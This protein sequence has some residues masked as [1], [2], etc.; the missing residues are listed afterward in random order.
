VVDVR[1][2]GGGGRAAAR[3]IRLRS[4]ATQVLAFSGYGD[5]NTVLGMLE[6]GAVG[7]LVKGESAGQ[8]LASIKRTT[9]GQ[10]SLSAQV[11]GELIDEVLS[12][13]R[14]RPRDEVLEETRGQIRRAVEDAGSRRVVFQP[15]CELGARRLAGVEALAR[16]DE[17]PRRGPAQ[18]FAEAAEVGL[19]HELEM[20]AIGEALAHLPELPTDVYLALNASPPTAASGELRDALAASEP[21]RI[22]VEI[23]EHAPIEDY[24]A[25]NAA[26]ARLRDLG[27]RVAVDDAGA[28]FASL[29]HI[30]RLEPSFIKLDRSLIGGIQSDRNRQALA[31]GLVSFAQRADASIVAEGIESSEELDALA[32]LG[33]THGQGFYLARPGPLP[34]RA[35]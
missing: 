23:T 26:L 29:R 7:F 8:I 31:A 20:A 18:W 24:E 4:P 22:V 14:T 2:P 11:A 21:E 16:F 12:R 33:V 15:I 34:L 3:G 35:P 27:V 30:L 10:A 28:G 13:K 9:N 5:R 17:P 32:G 25:L 6:A 1:M 19:L